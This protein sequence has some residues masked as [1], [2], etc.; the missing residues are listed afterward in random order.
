[1]TGVVAQVVEYL[2]CKCEAQSS[3]SQSHKNEI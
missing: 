2:L 1:M 3:N